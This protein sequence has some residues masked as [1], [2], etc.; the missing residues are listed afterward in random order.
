[1]EFFKK[2][3]QILSLVAFI[4]LG[5]SSDDEQSTTLEIKVINFETSYSQ[6]KLNWEIVRPNGIIIEDLLIY[7]Q[8]KNNATDS[9]TLE[10]V[11]NLPSNETLFIDNDVPY[12]TEVSYTIKI[13]YT[14]ERLAQQIQ[15]TL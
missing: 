1:M 4:L 13:N 5:C 6:V 11:A 15:Q 12:K 3:Y 14:D 7:R 2:Q 8:S 10:L 9:A